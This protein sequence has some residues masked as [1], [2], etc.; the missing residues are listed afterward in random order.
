MEGYMWEDRGD[1]PSGRN[2]I[3]PER[4]SR[5]VG[6]MGT[7]GGEPRRWR[8]KS[9]ARHDSVRFSAEK[10]SET[11]TIADKPDRQR[12]SDIFGATG[13]EE[14]G[15]AAVSSC[16]R[17]TEGRW[18]EEPVKLMELST[19]RAAKSLADGLSAARGPDE[20][21]ILWS[22]L[23]MPSRRERGSVSVLDT[24]TDGRVPSEC[25]TLRSKFGPSSRADVVEIVCSPPSFLDDRQRIDVRSASS[26][27]GEI[28]VIYG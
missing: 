13:I 14:R 25:S 3:L 19:G 24:G 23:I 7:G 11:S 2:N 12:K 5:S 18:C 17:A 9:E 8:R 1:T 22:G 26:S 16:P 6:L 20:P 4:Q 28:S 21:I 27:T 10:R 15:W